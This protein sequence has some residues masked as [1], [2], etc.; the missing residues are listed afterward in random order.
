MIGKILLTFPALQEGILLKRYKRFLADV[1]LESGEI[2]TAHC[3]NTGPMTGV[4]NTGG[5]VRVRYAP[6]PTRKL[7]W[8]WEQA[9]VEND[10]KTKTWVGINTGLPNK[11]VRRVVEEGLLKEELGEIAE[12]RN[13]VKYGKKGNSRIDMLLTPHQSEIDDRKIYL[14]VKNTTWVKNSVAFFPDTITERGQKH[15]IDMID[16]LPK[17]KAVLVPCISRNDVDS[18]APGDSADPKYGELFRLALSSGVKVLP[19]C[20]GFYNDHIT[21]EGLRPYNL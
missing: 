9:E 20:F 13:E 19:C 14:E 16:V 7:S 10:Q 12:L 11:I 17:S 1:K 3:A 2:V 5:K 18:F 8:S 6:S 15:L 4:L 21:W